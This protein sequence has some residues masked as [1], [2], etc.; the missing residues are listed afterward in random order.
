MDFEQD[1]ESTSYSTKDLAELAILAEKQLSLEREKEDLEEQLKQVERELQKVSGVDI[2]TV[3][4]QIGMSD[5]MLKSGERIKVERKIKASIPK[6]KQ[7]Q[8]FAW[9][10]SNGFDSLIKNQ[11]VAAFGKGED[12]R[13]KELAAKLNAAGFIVSQSESVHAQTLGAFV[14][15]QMER[16]VELP[17]DLLGIFEFNITKVS[18]PKE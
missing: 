4:D 14:R 13:A 1:A 8:A 16:G 10:R 11:V 12:Q 15:E 5:F 2:P 9:L 18:K 7:D 6:T 17:A 3:M